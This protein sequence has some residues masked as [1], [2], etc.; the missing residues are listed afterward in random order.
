[1]KKYFILIASILIQVCLGVGYSWSTFVPALKQTYGI[2]I[3]QTQTIF[4]T[5]S[6]IITLCIFV[7]GRIQDRFGPRIPVFVG[8]IIL[9]G[10]YLLAGY[11][12]GSYFALLLLVGISAAIGVGISYVCPIVCSVKWFPRHKSLTTGVVVAGYGGSPIII[13]L[14]GE[15]LLSHQVN[16]LTIFKYLG[17]VFLIIV[18]V[19]AMILQ[20]PIQKEGPITVTT[21]IKTT[22]LLKDRNFWG[23]VCGIFPCQCIGL[24]TIGNIKPFSLSLNL[25]LIVTGTAVSIL[26]LSNALGRIGWGIIGGFL[27]G[28]TAILLSLIS[29]SIVCLAAALAVNNDLSF[30]LFVVSAGFNYGACL[31]LY[32]AE[33]A[34]HYG[35]EKMGTIYS[36]LFLSNAVAGFIAPLLAGKIF[37]N[38]ASY[39][40]AFLIFGFLAFISIFLFYFIYQ[41]KK[42]KES[43]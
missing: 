41:P 27:E 22:E 3:T 28:K 1:M 25:S 6:L 11:S 33:V 35:T 10:S 39:K 40:S 13:S 12:S 7:G 38:T 37:D 14:I 2:S 16:V 43:Y 32:A 5:T 30:F 9:G 21:S 29:T 23:L 42:H 20:N 34:S 4:G 17:L 26:A 8:G 15:F 31:V 18:P 19:A 36:T 24:M